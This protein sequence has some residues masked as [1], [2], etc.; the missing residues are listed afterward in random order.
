MQ[1]IA[2][3]IDWSVRLSVTIVRPAKAAELIVM[4][5]QMLTQ[6][7]LRKYTFRWGSSPHAWMGQF[8]GQKGLARDMSGHVQ[9]LI[10]TK[11]LS[12]GQTRHGAEAECGVLDG[13]H[14]APPGEYDWSI[15]VWQRCGLL[16]SYFVHLFASS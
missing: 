2:T 7:D 14:L 5:F 3:G 4:L 16:S 6:D 11:R 1:P 12:R 13:A 15:R 10:Y 8:W 9:R